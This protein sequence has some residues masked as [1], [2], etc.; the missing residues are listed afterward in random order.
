MATNS[1][2]AASI[3]EI[4]AALAALVAGVLLE[5]CAAAADCSRLVGL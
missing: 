3:P 4:A 1:A 2:R 5:C